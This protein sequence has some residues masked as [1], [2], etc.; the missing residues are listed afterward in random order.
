MVYS[1]LC[2]PPRAIGR[3]IGR[4]EDRDQDDDRGIADRAEGGSEHRIGPLEQVV[5]I[6]QK[7]PGQTLAA[8]VFARS[9]ALALC[10]D[11]FGVEAQHLEL[12]A[13]VLQLVRHRLDQEIRLH[14]KLIAAP[15][16]ES[17]GQRGEQH[18]SQGQSQRPADR[19][20]P[21]HAAD[22]GVDQDAD[23]NTRTDDQHRLDD[24]PEQQQRG[25]P[26]QPDRPYRDVGSPAEAVVT[27][28][29]AVAAI[30]IWGAMHEPRC[31]ARTLQIHEQGPSSS[32]WPQPG[33]DTN[34]P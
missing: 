31:V 15:R 10:A 28:A 6:G 4:R 30:P 22:A 19:H 18:A 13:P 7:K 5:G 20:E 26:A 1:D 8:G 25:G 29:R 12:G 23:Q 16:K 17:R 33:A 14:G 27:M 32:S 2:S 21:L 9:L 34:R 11:L 3:R 24:L